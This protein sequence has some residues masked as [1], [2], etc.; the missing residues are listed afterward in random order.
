LSSK[1]NKNSISNILSIRYDPND[2]PSRNFISW[3]DLRTS[4]SDPLG[5]KTENLL[6][7]SIK[8]NLVIMMSQFLFH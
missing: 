5:N 3:K 1:I 6:E 8:T 7:N 2:K 4:N